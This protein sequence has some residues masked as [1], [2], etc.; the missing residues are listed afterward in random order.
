[1]DEISL[2]AY[3]RQGR[4]RGRLRLPGIFIAGVYQWWWRDLQLV[5]VRWRVCGFWEKTGLVKVDA[6]GKYDKVERAAAK[7]AVLGIGYGMQANSL[8]R[9]I[10]E[11]SKPCTKDEAQKF[12]DAFYSLYKVYAEFRR[13]TYITYKKKD[14]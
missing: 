2:W 1:M 13:E 7:A 11:D 10:S 12:I 8:A 9:R 14:I 6:N 3:K 5:Y 4:Y